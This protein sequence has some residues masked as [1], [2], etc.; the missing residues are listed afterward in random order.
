M[1]YKLLILFV[2]T[3][4][5]A[6]FARNWEDKTNE[7]LIGYQMWLTQAEADYQSGVLPHD[8]QTRKVLD[9]AAAAHRLLVKQFVNYKTLYSTFGSKDSLNEAKRFVERDM[10]AVAS[11]VAQVKEIY[12]NR[13][14]ERPREQEE[15]GKVQ[16]ASTA[17]V[18]RTPEQAPDPK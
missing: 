2:L 17:E 13:P 9:Q 6:S 4:S 15:E 11:S 3:L 18:E 7:R 14:L 5:S 12:K 8:A 10:E 16:P 1:K